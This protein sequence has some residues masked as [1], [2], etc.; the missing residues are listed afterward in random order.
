MFDRVRVFPVRKVRL[1]GVEER[2]CAFHR[3][4]LVPPVPN[5]AVRAV[6]QVFRGRDELVHQFLRGRVQVRQ[7]D[8]DV[9]E[10]PVLQGALGRPKAFLRPGDVD[11]RLPQ[12][13]DEFLDR[14]EFRRRT[15]GFLEHTPLVL[16]EA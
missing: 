8:V 14:D 2:D 13:F 5:L 6:D 7:D 3:E 15:A 9:V 11:L 1:R 16:L 10:V 4:L 12:V